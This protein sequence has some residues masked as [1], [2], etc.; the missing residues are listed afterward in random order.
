M[1]CS[2]TCP[3][4]FLTE[5]WNA[6]ITELRKQVEELFEKKYGMCYTPFQ[7]IASTPLPP[8]SHMSFVGSGTHKY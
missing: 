5:K 8:E 4:L 3:P 2:L 1:V 7:A 6:R